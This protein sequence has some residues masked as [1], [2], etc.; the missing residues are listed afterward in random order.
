MDVRK[1]ATSLGPGM[2]LAVVHNLGTRDVA[3]QMFDE[4]DGSLVVGNVRVVSDD[5]V[6]I[7]AQGE[8]TDMLRVVVIG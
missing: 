7:S 4:V 8:K 3:V 1:Y 6:N 5:Q 2:D